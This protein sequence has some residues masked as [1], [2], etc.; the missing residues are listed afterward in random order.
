MYNLDKV[1]KRI[2]YLVKKWPNIIPENN[3]DELLLEVSVFK[4]AKGI[5][6]AKDLKPIE[7]F[8]HLG[9]HE[10]G[11]KF[12]FLSKLGK[13]L[14]TMYNSSSA[15][16]TDFSVMNG[17]TG[18]SRKSSTQQS[19]LA[20]RMRIKSN[21]YQLKFDC[22]HCQEDDVND[23]EEDEKEEDKKVKKNCHCFLW[24]PSVSLVDSMSG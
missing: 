21:V 24:K 18:Y 14:L 10:G 2:G 22:E 16:E 23:N 8:H 15:A 4:A 7:F 5:D 6:D 20:A 3:V 9:L 17:L 12:F 11:K 1:K 13:A 19:K